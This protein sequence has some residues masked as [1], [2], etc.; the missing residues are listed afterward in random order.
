[1]ILKLNI[2]F[3]TYD[4][5]AK[6]NVEFYDFNFVMNIKD[7]KKFFE[8]FYT[9]FNAAIVSLNYINILKMFNLKRLINTR[10]KYR[11]F[12]EN[13]IL[14]Q[15]LIAHLRYIA[16]NLKIINKTFLNKNNKFKG[17]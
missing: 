5:V 3:E 10:L 16:A 4:K 12:N 6:S 11:I 7:K 13:Y 1:M 14:F 9:R 17:D 15:D 8:I 2:M